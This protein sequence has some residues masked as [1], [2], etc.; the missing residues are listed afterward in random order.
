MHYTVYRFGEYYD[1]V[2]SASRLNCKAIKRKLIE[3]GYP[4]NIT[5][6]MDI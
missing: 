5:V 3:D 4:T 2:Y 1:S 6:G